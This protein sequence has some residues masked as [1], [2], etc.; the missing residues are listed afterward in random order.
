MII[1][2]PS[3]SKVKVLS[4]N[5][6]GNCTLVEVLFIIPLLHIEILKPNNFA[7]LILIY[8]SRVSDI[9]VRILQMHGISHSVNK[10][11][12]IESSQYRRL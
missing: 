11:L 4:R 1:G 12:N 3:Q 6:E 7:D 9:T 2:K 8:S 10:T 5:L